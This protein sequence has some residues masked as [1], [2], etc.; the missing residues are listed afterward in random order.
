[1]KTPNIQTGLLLAMVVASTVARGS[2]TP[3]AVGNLVWNDLNR[4]G[5][6]DP[7]EPGLNGV[8][9]KAFRA[10]NNQ[11]V[12][13]QVTQQIGDQAGNY[14]FS[15]DQPGS[16]YLQFDL[17]PTHSFTSPKQGNNDAVDSDVDRV[18]GQTS[19][20]QI[21]RSGDGRPQPNWDAGVVTKLFEQPL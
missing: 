1:M 3:V 11:L 21:E 13:T 18:T 15:F 10:P 7:G 6:Q 20:I 14:S 16:I 12:G 2:K 17:P 9:V 8:V 5:I 4:N 19:T